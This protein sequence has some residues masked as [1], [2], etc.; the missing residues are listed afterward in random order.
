MQSLPET[1]GSPLAPESGNGRKKLQGPH[2]PDLESHRREALRRGRNPVRRIWIL[3]QRIAPLLIVVGVGVLLFVNATLL[4]AFLLA[5]NFVW[6]L[7]FGILITLFQFVAIFWFMSRSR[8]ERIRPE[9][10]KVITFDD[11][12]GQANLKSLVRQ[13]LGLLSDRELFLRMGGRYI[14]G[15]LLYGEP[16]T[17]QDHARQG[18][19][20]RGR[21]GLHLNGRLG[22]PQH[23]LGR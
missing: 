10:P 20:R 22:L 7:A 4:N 8:V 14:N 11:Y 1:A 6:Q 21:S 19:G 18:D 16:G 17:G 9:D 12:W 23:V 13:W 5:L 3:L 15:L 2:V